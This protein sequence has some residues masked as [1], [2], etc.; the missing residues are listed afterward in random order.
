LENQLEK[1]EEESTRLQNYIINKNLVKE[2][3][4]YF[5]KLYDGL[6][7]KEKKHILKFLIKKII[8]TWDRIH[9]EFFEVPSVEKIL[10]ESSEIFSF[11]QNSA[12]IRS[13]IVLQSAYP[14]PHRRIVVPDHKEIA[15]G[16]LQKIVK[17]AG[18]TIEELQRLL[19]K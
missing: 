13:H 19:K 8:F 10:T 18:L 11:A 14:H 17:Q 5:N 6:S 3:F 7:Q 2:S 1:I 4:Q 16:T 9:I 12:R 15:K